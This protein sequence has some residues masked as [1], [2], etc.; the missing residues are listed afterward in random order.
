MYMRVKLEFG[1]K[2]VESQN[3]ARPNLLFLE[4]VIRKAE[5]VRSALKE[6]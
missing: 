6:I 1:A 2:S 3:D 5:R 4:I